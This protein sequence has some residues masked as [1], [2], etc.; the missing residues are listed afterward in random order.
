M[1]DGTSEV[2]ACVARPPL[3]HNWIAEVKFPKYNECETVRA[4]SI[5]CSVGPKPQKKRTPFNP[6]NPDDFNRK[7]LYEVVSRTRTSD[8]NAHPY[9]AIIGKMAGKAC[10]MVCGV[11]LP[12]GSVGGH[13]M[14][15]K[16]KS[17]MYLHDVSSFDS[18][19]GV[20]LSYV[21]EI[22]VTFSS[23]NFSWI[24]V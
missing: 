11:M 8:G 14:R 24:Y 16:A 6:Q 15:D 21:V 5:I 17:E 23:C 4:S 22:H 19:S 13:F 2:A 20:F 10:D 1:S 7:V 3:W 18:P 12:R 9:Y